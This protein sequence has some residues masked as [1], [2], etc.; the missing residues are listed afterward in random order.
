LPTTT[1]VSTTSNATSP[2]RCSSVCSRWPAGEASL[3]GG[4][5]YDAFR[6]DADRWAVVIGD[7][8]GKGVDAAAITGLVRHTVRAAA[9]NATSPAEVLRDVHHALSVH[10]PSTFCTVCFFYVT[11]ASDGSQSLVIALGGHP[12]PV[13]RRA[14]GTVRE[15]GV[16]GSLLG[17]FEPVL[18][19]VT[20]A[21]APGDTIVLYTDGLTDAPAEQAVPI[22]ELLDLLGI[23]GGEP[24]ELLADS[25]RPLKRR[26]RPRGSADDTAIVVLRFGVPGEPGEWAP[27]S[28]VDAVA[29]TAV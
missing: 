11:V 5:F 8:C 1:P 12:S 2:R 15:I 24:V 28:D 3:I 9:R 17:I 16:P 18:T 23:E 13:L 20:V 21:V 25:I 6:V 19:D 27:A 26:R 29:S 10:Q 7:V 4:D 14:D 22:E